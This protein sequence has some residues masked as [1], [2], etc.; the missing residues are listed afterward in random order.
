MNK[1]IIGLTG[2]SG[3]GKTTVSNIFQQQ[4]FYVLNADKISRE[5]INY[6]K[7][8]KTLSDTFGSN[9][10]VNGEL[11]RKTLSKIVFS[12]KD[13]LNK[14]NNIMF[15]LIKS[16]IELLINKTEEKF[17][18]LDAP[19]LFEAEANNICHYVVS[20]IAP[21][22]KLLQRIIARDNINK[23]LAL[24]RLNSQYSKEYFIKNSDFIIENNGTI[25]Q[26]YNKTIQII[27]IVQIKNT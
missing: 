5:I 4:G 21:K 12:N 27:K 19:Q 10:I 1:I 3:A 20:V 11:N 14:L 16:K 17:I 22:D 24:K 9:I 15:P 13:S 18:L 26:L 8:L 25:E 2:Q 7:T 6:P 23:E